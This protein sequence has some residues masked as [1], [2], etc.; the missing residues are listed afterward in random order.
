MDDL[1]FYIRS[2]KGLESSVHT[3][4]IFSADIGMDFGVTKC[5]KLMVRKRKAVTTYGIKLPDGREFKSPEKGESY[6]YLS[7]LESNVVQ[8][9]EINKKLT[10]ERKERKPLQSKIDGGDVICGINIWA[11]S[12]LCYSA[13]F[14]NCT[15]DELRVLDIRTMKHL[16]MY[17]THVRVTTISFDERMS[18]I[19]FH[20]NDVNRTGACSEVVVSDR[21]PVDQQCGTCRHPATAEQRQKRLGWSKEDIKL[22][23]ECY[24]RSEPERRGH[25]KRLLDL[26]K[27]RNINSELTEVTEQRSAD[28]VRQIKNKKWRET[29]EQEEIAIRVRHEHCD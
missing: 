13:S 4:H 14:I 11:V 29:V 2:V 5:T 26:W 25:R 15:R 12:V 18:N 17:A 10:K 27:A 9:E 1:K 21:C 22:L 23:F 19:E 7:V 6:K 3:V 28:Q 24:I 20:T 8:C 16:T